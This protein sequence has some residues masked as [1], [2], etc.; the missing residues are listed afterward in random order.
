MEKIDFSKINLTGKNI[1]I[2]YPTA[3]EW[4]LVLT[5]EESKALQSGWFKVVRTSDEVKDI[6]EGQEA[7][8]FFHNQPYEFDETVLASRANQKKEMEK[9]KSKTDSKL[10]LPNNPFTKDE[11]KISRIYAIVPAH[12]VLIT[13][14]Y[15]DVG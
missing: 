10:I 4:G 9:E 3:T 2:A 7:F 14:E 1:L 13:R 15:I 6:K 12:S 8:V 5:H 11:D